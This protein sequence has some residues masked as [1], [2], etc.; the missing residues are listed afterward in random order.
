[1]YESITVEDEPDEEGSVMGDVHLQDA[2]T[3]E[4]QTQGS[5]NIRIQPAGNVVAVE[6]EKAS[7]ADSSFSEV[8]DEDNLRI[9]EELNEDILGKNDDENMLLEDSNQK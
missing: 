2:N 4:T 8:S 3:L 1:M 6:P 7:S 5:E 9:D